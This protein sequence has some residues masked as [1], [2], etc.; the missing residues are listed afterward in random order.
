MG[1]YPFG[2]V[3]ILVSLAI[4]A[5]AMLRHRLMDIEIVI[6]K[7]VY[8]SILTALLTG[9]FLSA[10]VVGD[11]WLRSTI[12]HGSV[13]LSIVAAFI[14]AMFF[15]PLRDA[16]QNIVD[17][18]FFR[19]RY[20]YQAIIN[21]YSGALARPMPDLNRFARLAPYLLWK[22]LRLAGA[23][24]M[25]L[26]RESGAYV[27]RAGVGDNEK[28]Q[29]QSLPL[30]SALIGDLRKNFREINLEEI[31]YSLKTDTGLAPEA[32][33]HLQQLKDEM[34]R[35]G[36]VLIIPAVSESDYFSEPTLLA[37]LNLSKKLSDE[38][39]SKE[40]IAFLKM[41]GNQAA[42][43]IEYAF[44]LE[45]LKKNQ[46]QVLKSE[47]LA[48]LGAAVAGIAHELKNPLTYLLTVAQAMAASWDNPDFR[49]SVVRMFPSEVE[50]M[51]LIIDGLSDYS[52]TRELA[53]E[54]VEITGVIDKTLAVLGY[55][56]KKHNAFIIKNYPAAGEPAA[57][58]LADKNR[59]VQVFM[60]IIANGVQA[61]ADK[62][63]DLTITVR[64]QESEVR[65]GIA[66]TGPG[67]PE[68]KLRKIFDPFFTT[69]AA[70]TGLG[71][72][73]TK[74]IVDDHK[75]AI[76]VDSRVGEGTTFTICLPAA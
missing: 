66:D 10:I 75:G 36:T 5:Y 56:I 8:Y 69:K 65:V 20:N 43:S 31:T 7:T 1:F 29:G 4:I 74:K 68:D 2:F 71:L 33:A 46:E 67:I 25:S 13:W 63:G 38:S 58:A 18:L 26:D 57:V 62:G 50:R 61:L 48:S 45:E 24:F 76:Y 53:I 54:P 55:E 41:L 59:I 47:K 12:G 64:R 17:R 40:D 11:Y 16:I 15:Q 23:A 34:E 27:V 39:Y 42:I 51:K 14:V 35:L 49:E 21:R 22:S 28:V 70:G 52:K 30:K 37:T 72:S 19:S 3:A 44:I 32:R 6:K 73:I 60:N 9:V